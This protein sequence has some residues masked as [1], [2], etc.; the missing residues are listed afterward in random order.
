MRSAALLAIAALLPG[1]GAEPREERVSPIDPAVAAAL[2]DPLMIDPLLAEQSDD[3][4]SLHALP[5]GSPT[6][7][8]FSSTL[9]AFARHHALTPGFAGCEMRLD[10]TLAWA[11]RLPPSLVLPKAAQMREAAGSDT[12]ACRLRIVGYTVEAPPAQALAHYRA[13]ARRHGFTARA[14]DS[15]TL[16]ATKAGAAFVV[17]VVPVDSGSAVALMSRG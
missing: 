13:V 3:A 2:A 4:P 1:C 15:G 6:G 11:T 5:V 17:R 9:T 12:S 10:Y 16:S 8:A 14:D 7:S